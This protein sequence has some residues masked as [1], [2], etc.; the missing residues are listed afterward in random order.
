M[1]KAL[2]IAGILAGG[3]TALSSF[4]VGY[5]R[6]GNYYLQQIKEKRK[7]VRT[8]SPYYRSGYHGSPMSRGLRG[9]K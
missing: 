2:L 9:G 8:G 4:F 1:W 3:T 6:A 7:S 5:D